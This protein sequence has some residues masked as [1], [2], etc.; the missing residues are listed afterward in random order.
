MDSLIASAARSLAAGDPLGALKRIALR[1]DPP[2][3]ALRG[4]AMAQLGDYERSRK[5]LRR[6]ARGFG[7]R[8]RLA[9]ARCQVA[10]AEVALAARD[11]RQPARALDAAA[12]AL[13][14]LGDRANALHARLVG[15][16]RQ[17]LV[18]DLDAAE[19]TLAAVDVVAADAPPSLAARAELTRAE[20]ALRR[21]RVADAAAALGR[22]HTAAVAAGIPALI[23]EIDRARHTLSAPSARLIRA[24]VVRSV[25]L[26]EVEALFAS[27]D[28]VVDACRRVVRGP[29]RSVPLAGR[30]VLFALVGA[31]AEAWPADVP[32]DRLIERVFRARIA[33]ESHR[34]RLRVELSR[35]RAALRP[36]ARIEAT[37]RGFALAPIDA[38]AVVVLAPP[39]DGPA[40]SILAL[41]E[42]GESWSTSALARALGSSQRTLQRALRQL[43]ETAAVR[44]VGRGRSRR[45]L[46]PALG[47]FAT[48]LLLPGGLPIE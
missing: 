23:A 17:L 18:G 28:L 36:L 39:I 33:S 45:W 19:Q 14:A 9:R 34:A 8:E 24:G 3:L 13:D 44:A 25:R 6:A 2:A 47:G 22:A 48:N 26:D 40:G 37:A 21:V 7:A 20:L 41:L 10:E 31:L 15:A 11:L 43:E 27:S 1:D 12:Q 30:P 29:T 5:L 32:R 35:L 38:P 4:I 46:A 42:S 16:R